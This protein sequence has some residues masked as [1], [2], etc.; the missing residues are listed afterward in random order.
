VGDLGHAR[1]DVTSVAES[2]A[3]IEADRSARAAA[4]AQAKKKL[5]RSKNFYSTFQWRKLRYAVI[6]ECDGRCQACGRSAKD[7]I[8][9]NVDHIEPLSKAWDRRL[10]RS[11]LQVLCGDCNHGKLNYAAKDWRPTTEGKSE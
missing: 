4:D 10:D 1:R 11:N 7:G 6:S 2:I 3:A 5:G 9:L 8:T